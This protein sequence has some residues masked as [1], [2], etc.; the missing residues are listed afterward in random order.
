M[1]GIDTNLI[2]WV[3]RNLPSPKVDGIV[4]SIPWRAGRYS[5]RYVLSPMPTRQLLVDE[6]VYFAITNPTPGTKI[7][8]GSAGTQASFSDTVPFMLVK[9]N[10]NPGGKRLF[11]DYV[12]VIQ[13]GGTAPATTT[14]V[15]AAVKIDNVNRQNTAGTLT[16]LTPVN[17]NMGL[18]V[19]SISQWFVPAGAVATIPAS[20]G[21]ARLV[22]RAML[23]GGPT[24]LL[25]EYT[26]MFGPQD[27]PPMGGYLTTVSS[28]IT[29]MPPLAL[30]PQQ[31]AVI[32][33]W[34]PGGATNPF[35][36]EFEIGQWER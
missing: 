4:D 14:S 27:V 29:R 6:G 24:L 26:I 32:Y 35:S 18:I 7:D 33:L 25:D 12:K 19:G 36:F 11:L 17:A 10:D 3:Q 9:N 28:Y 5:E 13:I 22:G 1:P 2:G 20:S 21:S 23:K 30:D 31:W 16:Q 15:Q 8:Y 34:L